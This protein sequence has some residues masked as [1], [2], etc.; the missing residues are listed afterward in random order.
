M[1]DNPIVLYLFDIEQNPTNQ[2]Y[3]MS[4]TNMLLM[5]LSE[6]EFFRILVL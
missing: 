4:D 3:F 6:F 1:D 5:D 2:I